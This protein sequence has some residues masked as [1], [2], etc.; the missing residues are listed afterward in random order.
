MKKVEKKP[1]PKKEENTFEI[2]T[3]SMVAPDIEAPKV[4]KQKPVNHVQT[5]SKSTKK[6]K[7]KKPVKKEETEYKIETT[8]ADIT[9]LKSILGD[10]SDLD[11]AKMIK[12]EE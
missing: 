2:V 12:E 8:S 6:T 5:D 10:T 1:A 11:E 4:Q 9:S 7:N 3:T